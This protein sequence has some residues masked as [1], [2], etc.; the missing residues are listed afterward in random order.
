MNRYRID[1]S[2]L[3]T[4][5]SAFFSSCYLGVRTPDARIYEIALDVMQAEPAASLFV[6][7]REET[8]RERRPSAFARF[9]R[10]IPAAS[11]NTSASGYK[12]LDGTGRRDRGRERS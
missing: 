12:D 10:Q 3:R 4:I 5:F 1:T 7:D 11:S 9:T 8:W 2:G 6:D